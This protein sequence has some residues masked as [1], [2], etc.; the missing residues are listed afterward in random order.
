MD[1]FITDLYQLA[2]HCEYGSLY[3]ELVR[4]RIVVGIKD[5]KLSEK[6]LTLETAITEVRHSEQ[7]KKHQTVVRGEAVETGPVLDCAKSPE[8][9]SWEQHPSLRHVRGAGRRHPMI[10]HSVL[11]EKLFVVLATRKDTTSRVVEP[12]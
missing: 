3:D 10:N 2:D 5:A 8:A 11:Q 7:V 6:N 4:D 1:E 12:K 9:S